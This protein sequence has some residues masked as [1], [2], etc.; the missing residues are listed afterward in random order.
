MKFPEQS[1]SKDAQTSLANAI[2]LEAWLTAH[3][4]YAVTEPACVEWLRETVPQSVGVMTEAVLD[5]IWKAM[6]APSVESYT[7]ILILVLRGGTIGELD[8]TLAR[9]DQPFEA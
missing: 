1:K 2:A 4:D 8:D 7:T 6:E 5:R 3:P 9:L